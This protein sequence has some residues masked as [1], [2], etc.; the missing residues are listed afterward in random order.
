ML[1]GAC[2]PAVT[3]IEIV[4]ARIELTAGDA[5]ADVSVIVRDAQG[6]TLEASVDHPLGIDVTWSSSDPEVARVQPFAL[7]RAWRPQARVLPAS[8]GEATLTATCCGGVTS[9]APVRV[10]P[11]DTPPR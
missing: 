6:R 1:G 5:A 10:R 3:S 11:V 9:S 7:E 8:P 4:P 2:R